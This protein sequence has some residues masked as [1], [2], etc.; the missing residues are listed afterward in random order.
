MA[1]DRNNCGIDHGIFHIR[2]I[3]DRREYVL[4]NA[5]LGPIIETLED[6]IPVAEF[7][8]QVPP[9]AVRP[10]LPKDSFKKEPV[11]AAAA[12]WIGFLAPAMRLHLLPLPVRQYQPIPGL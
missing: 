10:R 11:V 9:G 6:R 4:E 2:I 5:S 1:V 7:L 12:A 8:W 3:R